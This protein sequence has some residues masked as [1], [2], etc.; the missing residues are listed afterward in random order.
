MWSKEEIGQSWPG[1][2]TVVLSLFGLMTLIF[3]EKQ[4]GGQ[5]L[6]VYVEYERMIFTVL[7]IK[8]CKIK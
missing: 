2:S 6:L 4:K 3:W 8:K 5:E 7:E 1:Q